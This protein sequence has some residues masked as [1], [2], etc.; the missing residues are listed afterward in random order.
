MASHTP[1]APLGRLA[2]AGRDRIL[3]RMRSSPSVPGST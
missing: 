2:G 3:S 1:R